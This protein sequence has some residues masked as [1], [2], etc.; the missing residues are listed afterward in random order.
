MQE[1]RKQEEAMECK[2]AGEGRLVH[3]LGEGWAP[4]TRLVTGKLLGKRRV[5]QHKERPVR[6]ILMPLAQLT[7]R[8]STRRIHHQKGS[9]ASTV[10]QVVVR[11]EGP[12]HRGAKHDSKPLAEVVLVR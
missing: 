11:D 12:K 9:R 5:V 1:I 7:L 10:V 4:P 6:N 8:V 3:E 2:V